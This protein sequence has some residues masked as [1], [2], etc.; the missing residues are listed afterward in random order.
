[1]FSKS[2]TPLSAQEK[3]AW[4]SV[5]THCAGQFALDSSLAGSLEEPT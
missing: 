2:G 3:A 4:I 1:M 5:N